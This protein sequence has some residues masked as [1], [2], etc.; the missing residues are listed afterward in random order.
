MH[1][2]QSFIRKAVKMLPWPILVFL[3]IIWTFSIPF[4]VIVLIA[5]IKEVKKTNSILSGSF[6][7]LAISL[8]FA[9]LYSVRKQPSA[10]GSEKSALLPTAARFF[11]TPLSLAIT[12]IY[13]GNIKYAY[14]LAQ[15]VFA[16]HAL[17]V[18]RK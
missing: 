11:S 3:G 18:F 2:P 10:A 15:F 1:I 14:W 4:Y 16:Y 5:I 9:D 13:F 8:G 17:L 7:K 12:Q 6:F